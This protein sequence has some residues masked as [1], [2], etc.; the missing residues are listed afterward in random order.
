MTCRWL[1]AATASRLLQDSA[2]YLV[3]NMSP[4]KLIAFSYKNVNVD[5]H[6]FY[7]EVE[8]ALRRWTPIDSR[9][10]DYDYGKSQWAQ[11]A[12]TG[13]IPS[14]R[15]AHTAAAVGHSLYIFGGRSGTYS[16]FA[17]LLIVPWHFPKGP[18]R[19]HHCSHW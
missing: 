2:I 10:Y 11:R 4:G 6:A 16:I 17:V 1:A 3:A 13:E 7:L 15:V 8:D 5:A 9:L 12:C 14:P 19:A 18:V